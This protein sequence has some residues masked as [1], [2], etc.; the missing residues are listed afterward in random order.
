MPAVHLFWC[1]AVFVRN[2][3]G[4]EWAIRGTGNM[5]HRWILSLGKRESAQW[6][7]RRQAGG[8]TFCRLRKLMRKG[9]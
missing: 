4:V 2:G 1:T 8:T 3:P 6:A 9:E 5:C 7:P